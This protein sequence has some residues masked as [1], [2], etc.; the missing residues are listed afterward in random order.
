MALVLYGFMFTVYPTLDMSD[1]EDEHVFKP[2]GRQK[3]DDTWNPKG[4][5]ECGALEAMT[6]HHWDESDTALS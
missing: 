4:T 5:T 6:I 1:N 2:R 3:R